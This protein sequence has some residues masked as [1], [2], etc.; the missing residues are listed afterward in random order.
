MKKI[1]L[2]IALAATINVGINAQNKMI[3]PLSEDESAALLLPKKAI[4][5]TSPQQKGTNPSVASPAGCDSLGTLWSGGNSQNGNMFDLFN[6]SAVPVQIIS[7]DQ[8]F[9]T[10]AA[11]SFE[12]WYKSGTFVGSEATPGAWTLAG[13]V[14]VTPSATF[15]AVTPILVTLTVSIPAGGTYG[16][17]LTNE[18]VGSNNAYTNGTN[19]G[20]PISTKNGLQAL[21]GRGIAYPFGAAFGTAPASRKWNGVI[22]YC[23]SLI[24]GVNQLS[25]NMNTSVF[26]NPASSEVNVT[27][28]SNIT[29]NNATVKMV[30]MSGRLISKTENVNNNNILLNTSDI[31]SGIYMLQ[32]ENNGS[33]IVNKK[34]SIQ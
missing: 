22:N 11:D 2:S 27:I 15:P 10:L 16:F 6:S 21:E 30:D 28:A 25:V 1:Y 17:Y 32:V 4:S 29:L 23:S 14:F 18:I 7:F 12:V 33:L 9:A 13:R 5:Y 3:A 26:P 34:V 19:Q 24:L 20:G 31:K 8:C